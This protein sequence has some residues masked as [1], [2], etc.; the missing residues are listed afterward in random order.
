MAP[1]VYPPTK[2]ISFNVPAPT[3]AGNFSLY[4]LAPKATSALSAKIPTITIQINITINAVKKTINLAALNPEIE[5]IPPEIVI[6]PLSTIFLNTVNP[7]IEIIQPII[8]EVPEL[9]ITLEGFTPDIESQIIIVDFALVEF[10]AYSPDISNEKIMVA[11]KKLRCN[12]FQKVKKCIM[13]CP[14]KRECL[15]R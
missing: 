8:V 9:N 3:L 14:Y 12:L 4:I 7:E 2:V 1:I 6:I 5:I 10:S 11:P 13:Y 15:R